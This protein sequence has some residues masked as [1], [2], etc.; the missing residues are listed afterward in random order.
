LATP[1]AVALEGSPVSLSVV[2]EIPIFEQQQGLANGGTVQGNTVKPNYN[3]SGPSGPLNEVGVKLIVT[4]R[5]YGVSNVFLDL[6]PEISSLGPDATSTLGGQVS[7]SPT[8]LRKTI[9]TQ[10]M[11]P[12]G[13]TLVLG[14]L[15]QDDTIKSRTKVPGLG[16]IPGIGAAFRSNSKERN[17]R[18]LLVFVTPTIVN[19]DDY[20]NGERGRDFLQTK[21]VDPSDTDWS[22]WDSTKVHEFRK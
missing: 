21:A 12:T 19:E 2:Q 13:S 9:M 3:M 10:A 18:D 6:K 4:P 11:V 22:D 5:I 15:R 8:F 1:R 7:T 20:Q 16:D 14:G 17:K